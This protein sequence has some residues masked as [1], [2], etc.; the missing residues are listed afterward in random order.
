MNILIRCIKFLL[1]AVVVIAEQLVM[2]V[3]E[4]LRKLKQSLQ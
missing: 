2:A 4:L 1:F 3:L